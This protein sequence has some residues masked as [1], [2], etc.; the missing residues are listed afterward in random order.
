MSLIR[1]LAL[2]LSYIYGKQSCFGC[3]VL[4]RVSVQLFLG[5]YDVTEVTG[6]QL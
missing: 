6:G 5:S 3:V 4:V 2:Q 1:V